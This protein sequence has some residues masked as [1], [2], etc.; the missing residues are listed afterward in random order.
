[1]ERE[2]TF[3]IVEIESSDS[4][5]NIHHDPVRQPVAVDVSDGVVRGRLT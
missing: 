5:R 4:M 3:P 1:V 2:V